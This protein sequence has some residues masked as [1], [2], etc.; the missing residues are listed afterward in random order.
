MGGRL[1]RG[2]K[3][4]SGNRM[5]LDLHVVSEELD[6]TTTRYVFELGGSRLSYGDA[7]RGILDEVAFRE[8]IIDVLSRSP[9]EAFFWELPPVSADSLE[10]AFEFVLCDAPGL[11]RVNAEPEAF[12]EHFAGSENDGVVVFENLGGD[13]TLVVPC[14]RTESNHYTHL[15]A[16]VR[17]A[18]RS[19]V[20]ALFQR[21]AVEALERIGKRPL[22]LS[23]A[24]MGI[25]WLH[26]RLD[27]RPKYYCHA[28]YRRPTHR[29]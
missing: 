20:D 1:L 22:W 18:D 14:P 3:V 7:L 17:A 19:Q 2:S 24:G 29:P 4:G 27:S 25:S 13:A 5:S 26:V 15:A 9:F 12:A 21:V 11:A 16:F 28:P 10:S 23:T 6:E 8:E